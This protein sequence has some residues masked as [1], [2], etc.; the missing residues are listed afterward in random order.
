MY[1]LN[2]NQFE[3][4]VHDLNAY[5]SQ[6]N[7]LRQK[8]IGFSHSLPS[9]LGE[10]LRKHFQRRLQKANDQLMLGELAIFIFSDL[11]SIPATYRD[12]IAFPWL[13][14]YEHALV[15][16]DIL[17][18]NIESS[19]NLILSQV[20]LDK[21]NSA[22]N[23][24]FQHNPSVLRSFEKYRLESMVAMMQEIEW[25]KG[26]VTPNRQ[27]I[28]L[29]QGRKAA[30]AKFCAAALQF[31]S[32]KNILEPKQ[33]A[34]IDFLLSGIQL[35]DD[36]DDWYDDYKSGQLNYLQESTLQWLHKKMALQNDKINITNFG[37]N[38]ILVGMILSGSVYQTWDIASY[39]ITRALNYLDSPTNTG[40]FNYFQSL[41]ENCN[42]SKLVLKEKITQG[43]N[44]WGEVEKALIEGEESLMREL[45]LGK[46]T[47]I[48]REI[49]KRLGIGPK[50]S[51]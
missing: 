25:S 36:F 39:N 20:L 46:I 8:L 33:E 45:N 2:I 38:Q 41:V 11:L 51:N 43:G 22:F 44:A 32:Q 7:R 12:E 17:D 1:A 40:T 16:D 47:R 28:F 18:K 5:L 9:P 31:Q 19:H 26:T 4:E 23:E 37:P 21:A 48:W 3:K 49:L 34:G 30:L 6:I 27:N 24:L 50:A 29:Q 15:M 42:Y 10:Y 14:L 35:L 13:L